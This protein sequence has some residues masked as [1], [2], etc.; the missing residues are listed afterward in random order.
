MGVLHGC[1]PGRGVQCAGGPF[2]TCTPAPGEPL[3]CGPSAVSFLA[4]T[5]KLH[6]DDDC[7]EDSMVPHYFFLEK[8]DLGGR[9]TVPI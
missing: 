1:C 3:T 6:L 5:Y 4:L 2:P 9:V 8:P 7:A